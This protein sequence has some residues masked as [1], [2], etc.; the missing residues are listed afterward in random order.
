M[1]SG[2]KLIRKVKKGAG[3]GMS[4]SDINALAM[5]STGPVNL[6]GNAN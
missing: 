1:S 2:K 5:A 3:Q 4:K 6:T